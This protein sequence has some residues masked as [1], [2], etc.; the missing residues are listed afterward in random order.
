MTSLLPRKPRTTAPRMRAVTT[1]CKL[2]LFL[3]LAT[4]TGFAQQPGRY[5][6]I[7]P[8]AAQDQ[9]KKPDDKEKTLEEKEKADWAKYVK[10]P[11]RELV[12]QFPD[13]ARLERAI[14]DRLR[15]DERDAKR[16]PDSKYGPTV[17]FPAGPQVGGGIAYAPK[18]AT[19]PPMS[20]Q[21]EPL[22]IVHRRLHFEEKNA[23]RYGWDLGII[24]PFVSAAYFYKDVLLWPN[25]SR[26]ASRMG[27]G[28][29][30]PASASPVAR[31]R[32]CCTAGAD[33]HRHHRGRLF[34]T[35]VAFAIP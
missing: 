32:T 15:Q 31:R 27:S 21:H 24:Q 2:A 30:T 7:A 28:T 1:A 22:Y 9:I 10:Y 23:E 11:P 34:V 13:D 29:Q 8:L 17:R 35:G 33:H 12:M 6:T 5:S 3:G 26:P 19:Y 25:F 14:L 4:S 20:V 18:T 16:D